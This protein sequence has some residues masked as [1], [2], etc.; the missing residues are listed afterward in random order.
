MKADEL[1]QATTQAKEKARN[2][3]RYAPGAETNETTRRRTKAEWVREGGLM[4]AVCERG[5][6]DAGMMADGMVSQRTEGT[7][8]GG[9][10]Q[11][12]LKFQTE[13]NT[14]LAQA[15]GVSRE[16]PS[17]ARRRSQGLGR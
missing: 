4:D 1:R 13:W 8:Q 17:R 16:T 11:R 14:T 15:S 5:N 10:V 6:L 7:P 3:G 9:P 2:A 12:F